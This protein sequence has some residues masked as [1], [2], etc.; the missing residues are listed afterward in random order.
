V[1]D[2][3]AGEEGLHVVEA[4]DPTVCG[5]DGDDRHAGGSG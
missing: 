2:V 3:E 1:V 5:G 4:G